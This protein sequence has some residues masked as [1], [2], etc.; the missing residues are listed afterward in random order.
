MGLAEEPE[1]SK[2]GSSGSAGS[3]FEVDYK[4]LHNSMRQKHATKKRLDGS[5][6]HAMDVAKV[7]VL[8]CTVLRPSSTW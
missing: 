5:V 8:V 4:L 6:E 1:P 2:D 3:G 7:D